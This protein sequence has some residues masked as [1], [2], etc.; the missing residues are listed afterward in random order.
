MFMCVQFFWSN[1]I[2]VLQKIQNIHINLLV[3]PDQLPKV[4]QFTFSLPFTLVST[5]LEYKYDLQIFFNFI[6]VTV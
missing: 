5:I 2:S 4:L 1:I 3:G 6:T